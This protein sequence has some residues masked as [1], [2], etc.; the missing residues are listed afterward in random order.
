MKWRPEGS[1][2]K[3]RPKRTWTKVVHK[4]SQARKVYRED[5]MD[6]SRRR[7]LIKDD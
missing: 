1:R 3:S 4:E 5:A 7:K 2:P 6:R